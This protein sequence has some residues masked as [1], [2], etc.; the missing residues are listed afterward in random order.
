MRFYEEYGSESAKREAQAG[1]TR[2]RATG[3]ALDYLVVWDENPRTHAGDFEGRAAVRDG[4]PDA[5]TTAISP[6]YLREHC[7]RIRRDD[8]PADWLK[9][10][11]P[12]PATA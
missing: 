4:I 6:E 7:R 9:T 5:N 8:V 11:D 2:G 1:A 12:E 10:L 3:K